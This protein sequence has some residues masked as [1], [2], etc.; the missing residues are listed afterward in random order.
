M[1]KKKSGWFISLLETFRQVR[2][3]LHMN[4]NFQKKIIIPMS[5][6]VMFLEFK[7]GKRYMAPRSAQLPI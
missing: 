2:G 1:K 4:F 6:Q 7:F 5:L 3:C